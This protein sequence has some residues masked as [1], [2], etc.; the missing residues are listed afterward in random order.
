MAVVDVQIVNYKTLA[1]ALEC[2]QFIL[3]EVVAKGIDIAIYVGDNDSGDDLEDLASLS[4]R[5]NV[6]Y[7][8]SNR[9]YGAA[10]NYL[11]RLGASDFIL[12]L[13]PDA[14]LMRNF[15]I[16]RMLS[17]LQDDTFQVVGPRLYTSKAET[18]WW[19]HGELP[20]Y[21]RRKLCLNRWQERTKPTEVAWVSGACLLI[22]RSVFEQVGGFDE[23]FF[24]YKE[25]EDLCL[26]LRQ[27]GHRV[28]YDPTVSVYHEGSVVASKGEFMKKSAEYYIR[29]HCR[30]PWKHLALAHLR[31][32]HKF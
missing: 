20:G 29:K 8:P 31:R 11:S 5:V 21:F 10:N 30:G 32:R 13:N 15:T 12:I 25:E 28:L 24:L 9:G 19:D 22:K 7:L 6:H 16:S 26:R 3:L 1:Y 23:E 27:V 18:Q 14:Y 4:P 17:R 2:V